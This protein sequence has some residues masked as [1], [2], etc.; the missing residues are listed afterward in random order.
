MADRTNT[1]RFR[2]WLWLI[3]IIGVT[4]PLRLRANW[5]REWEAELRHREA[6]LAEWIGSTGAPGSICFGAARAHSGMRSGYNQREWRTKC[7]RTY[8]LVCECC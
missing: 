4:V 6:M 5:R 2:L 1:T 8:D 7:F 3:R